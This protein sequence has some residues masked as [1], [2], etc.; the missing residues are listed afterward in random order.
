MKWS[1][2]WD[3]FP[4]TTSRQRLNVLAV[5]THQNWKRVCVF[6]SRNRCRKLQSD[7]F[8]LFPL[9]PT[10]PFDAVNQHLDL[11]HKQHTDSCRQ[12]VLHLHVLVS[13]CS[14][15]SS[16]SFL[17]IFFVSHFNICTR[18]THWFDVITVGC[19][20]S[21]QSFRWTY[22]RTALPSSLPDCFQFFEGQ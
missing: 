22:E 20:I 8:C 15:D 17:L 21:I 5:S 6:L 18:F 2:L 19:Y 13:L 4:F 7:F 12:H 10:V 9:P 3:L 14:L 1:M 11:R 16:G